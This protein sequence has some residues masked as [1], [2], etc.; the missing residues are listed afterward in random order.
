MLRPPRFAASVALMAAVTK[1][2]A[3]A[4]LI[5]PLTIILAAASLLA[6]IRYK[7]NSTWLI[8]AGKTGEE[9]PGRIGEDSC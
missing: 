9:S 2:L 3:I 7:V 5:D 6:L 1:D 8:A 4:T